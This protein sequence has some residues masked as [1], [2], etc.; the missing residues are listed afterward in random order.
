MTPNERPPNDVGCLNSQSEPL[1]DHLGISPSK[2][3]FRMTDLAPLR[4]LFPICAPYFL[5]SQ[6][7]WQSWSSMS[8]NKLSQATL[9]PL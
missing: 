7:L 4:E 6:L 9:A 8:S 1:N 5:E 3:N 2:E